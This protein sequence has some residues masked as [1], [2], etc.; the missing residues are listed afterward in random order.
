MTT[1]PGVGAH[2]IGKWRNRF[3]TGRVEGLYDDVA[4]DLAR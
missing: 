3:I 2:T 1:G 4:T